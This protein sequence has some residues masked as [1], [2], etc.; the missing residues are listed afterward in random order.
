MLLER[1][2]EF[3][4][5]IGNPNLEHLIFNNSP[6]GIRFEIGYESTI[7]LDGLA[8]DNMIINPQYISTALHWAKAIYTAPWI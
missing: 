7:Y 6:V 2:N 3:L 8:P 1:F 4:V 5:K